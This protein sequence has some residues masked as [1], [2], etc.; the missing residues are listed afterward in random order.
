VGG[1]GA[2]SGLLVL[3]AALDMGHTAAVGEPEP[4]ESA[5]K[6]GMQRSDI[7]VPAFATSDRGGP[8]MTI[9]RE[10]LGVSAEALSAATPVVEP[11]SRWRLRLE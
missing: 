9:V 7:G 5:S 3:L 11:R 2:V 10:E 1:I 4:G 8:P 6:P